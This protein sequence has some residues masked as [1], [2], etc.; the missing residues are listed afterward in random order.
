[1]C[2]RY[3]SNNNNNKNGGESGDDRGKK[4]WKNRRICE[5]TLAEHSSQQIYATQD[6]KK[7]EEARKGVVKGKRG[8]L[9]NARRR[10]K[11]K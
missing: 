3:W 6:N 5:Q 8:P 11:V 10:R 9:A 4:E 1:M 2:N 7:S